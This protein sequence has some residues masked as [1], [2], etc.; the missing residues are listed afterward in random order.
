ML[1]DVS[2]LD[3]PDFAVNYGL[4]AKEHIDAL[5]V[6][7]DAF[8]CV[9]MA[10]IAARSHQLDI[11]VTSCRSLADA[12]SAVALRRYDVIYIE[13]WLDGATTIAFIHEMTR[14][15]TPCIVL[16]DLNEPDIRRIAF[17]AGAQAFLAKDA[18]CPQALESVTLTVLRSR[19]VAR[20]AA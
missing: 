13:Y 9:L 19:L 8:D 2:H 20:A 12:G 3:L 15:G 18:L 7:G 14:A 10:H 5:V 1:A 17:R 6:D 16:T 4:P 11:D